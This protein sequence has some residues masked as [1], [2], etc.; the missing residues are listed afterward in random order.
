ML[1]QRIAQQTLRRL[2][3]Q[4][5]A[6]RF[7]APAALASR[8]ALVNQRRLAATTSSMQENQPNT[9]ILA[10]QRLAR[11]VSPHLSIYRPQI[12]WYGSIINRITGSLM[13]GTFYLFGAAYLAAPVFG[14]HLETAT[15]AAAFASW[16]VILQFLT[17]VVFG[18]QFTYHTFNGVR[19]LMWDTASGITNKAVN[20]TGWFVM[21]LSTVSAVA[22]ALL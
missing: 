16:P 12:T 13:S 7:V 20:Q 11:P 1:S 18:W 5:P 9:E 19:H 22:L 15:I 6:A 17:K 3:L 21:G 4:N 14:W 2:A 10:K 8:N